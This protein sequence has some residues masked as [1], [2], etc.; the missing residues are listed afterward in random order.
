MLRR[1]CGC[2]LVAAS[3]ASEPAAPADPLFAPGRSAGPVARHSSTIAVSPD[4]ARVY[5]VN[6]DAD[7]V[8]V[9]DTASRALVR[10]IALGTSPPAAD[11]AGRFEPR[12]QPRAL[13]LSPGA[14]RLYVSGERS[15]D[16]S[17]VDLT[18]DRVVARV[19]ACSE[20][21]GV[22][23]APD[24]R[25]VFVA[26]SNDGS[27]VRIDAARRAVTGAAPTAPKPWGLA[28]SGDASTLYVSHLLGPG[29]S[30]FDAAGLRA[31]GATRLEAV[32]R[33]RDPRVPN[34]ESRGLYDVAVRQGAAAEELWLPHL[35]L[36]TETAQTPTGSAGA[37]EL[38]FETTVFP[39]MSVVAGGARVAYLSAASLGVDLAARRRLGMQSITS[40]PRAM[41]FTPD[42]RYAL[43]VNASSDDLVVIDAARRVEAPQG[44]VRP[45]GGRM[46]EGVVVA[47]D[48][49]RAYVDL[50]NTS[51]VAVLRLR[52]GAEGL[53]VTR[54]GETIARVARDPMPAALRLGQRV[55]YSANST[56]LPIT[57]NFWVACASCHVEGRSDGVVWRFKVGP[58]DT[59]SNAGGALG[60][61]ALLRTGMFAA[62]DDYWRVI[63]EEQGGDGEA[64]R[65]DP[66]LRP[67]LAA[68]RD[69][70][71]L[72]IPLPVPPRTDAAMVARGRALFNRDDVGC[73]T[74]HAGER[75]TDADRGTLAAP[76]LYDVGACNTDAA[77]PD[78]PHADAEGRP[79][80]A[81][82]FETPGL[83]GVADSAPYLHDGSAATLRDALERTRGRMGHIETLSEPEID[84]LVEYMR[85]L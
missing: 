24:E 68:L 34:G 40:G 46:P 36:S 60:T 25:T 45:L 1:A 59:P 19:T 26:C 84:A 71:N 28:W 4:G 9:I 16:V 52:A 29:V 8:S 33:V 10:E 76:R 48:G 6:A 77:W 14:R 73:A 13:A 85:S 80:E 63:T 2:A 7:S 11:D 49:A 15:G 22:L 78:R 44:L 38:D 42:G 17:I 70:V 3:C 72:A 62:V 21:A 66:T 75:F 82:L 31:R 47:P 69:Y 67:Y 74:C 65:D 56:E 39:A 41:D 30:A 12:V 37:L 55:F 58:R 27:L 57:Q 83:R 64:F 51:A 20:P 23:V 53:E 5:V 43:V 61:G 32:P 50:R 18:S 79:R 54:D 81:C 35:L